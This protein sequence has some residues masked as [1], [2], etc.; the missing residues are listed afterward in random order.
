MI[1][2]PS[3]FMRKS[4]HGAP[5]G[6]GTRPTAKQ[7]AGP[8]LKGRDDM[9]AANRLIKAGIRPDCAV[10]TVAWFRRQGDDSSLERYVSRAERKAEKRKECPR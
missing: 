2:F 5:A 3:F 1:C 9:D 4:V 7:P 6:G 10:E 8:L